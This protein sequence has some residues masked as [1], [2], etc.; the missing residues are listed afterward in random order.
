MS[1]KWYNLNDGFQPEADEPI[2]LAKEP[3]QD[4]INGCKIGS[5]IIHKDSGEIGW[6]VGNN[7]NII[8][9]SSRTYWAY[10][11]EKE[12]YIPDTD[13]IE[14]LVNCLQEYMLKLQCFEKK[15]QK[16]GECMMTS[17]KGIYPLDY[18]I[19]GILNRSLSLIYGFDT[20]VNSE[21][22]IGALHLVRPHLDN[23]LRLSAS[24]LVENP[25]DFAKDVWK[26]IA[27]KDIRDRS[28]KKMHDAYLKKKATEEF[29]WIENVYNE[30]S[31][32]VHFSNKHIVNATTLSSEKE[33][34]FT[35]FIGK[36]DNNVSYESKIEAV[37]GMIEI[38][39]L[40]SSSVYGWIVT[41]R[42][43]G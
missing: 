35:T 41:K 20:L 21:N 29:P 36:T 4:L 26:G 19:A 38:S 33:R 37:I 16:L 14:T 17:G 5:L 10:L 39:N 27:I 3:T 32:F 8:K 22:F 6:F 23:Y 15:I 9:S 25:H 42:M 12:L 13:D 11:S 30:T 24:W 18:F 34:T 1:I 43:K 7:C 28:G 40:I 31:A 2:L